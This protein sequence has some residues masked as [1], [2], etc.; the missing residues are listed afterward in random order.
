[1]GPVKRIPLSADH[2]N[3]VG[4]VGDRRGTVLRRTRPSRLEAR[5]QA[6]QYIANVLVELAPVAKSRLR[7][8]PS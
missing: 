7:P 8:S 1:M 2:G 3:A 4:V 5:T 6:G